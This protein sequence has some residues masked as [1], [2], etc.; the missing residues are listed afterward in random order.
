MLC[1]WWVWAKRGPLKLVHGDTLKGSTRSSNYLEDYWPCT[2]GLPAVNAI[3]TQ[4][5]DLI[6]SGLTRWR[7]AEQMGAVAGRDG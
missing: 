3:G 2:G 5:C 4:L 1:Q 6:D 7:L